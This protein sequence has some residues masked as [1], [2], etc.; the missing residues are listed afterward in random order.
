M[1][2]GWAVGYSLAFSPG[3]TSVIGDLQYAFHRGVGADPVGT[4]PAVLFS[5]FQM[6]FC[7]TVCAMSIG[8]SVERGRL[9]PIV[10]FIFVSMAHQLCNFPVTP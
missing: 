3:G 7:A 9:L 10:P 4:I 1:A 6:V 2:S 5:M 8:G